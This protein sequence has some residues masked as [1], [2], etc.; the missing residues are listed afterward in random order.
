MENRRFAPE[1]AKLQASRELQIS[2]NSLLKDRGKCKIFIE[3][4]LR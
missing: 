4:P 2:M 3:Y 1:S